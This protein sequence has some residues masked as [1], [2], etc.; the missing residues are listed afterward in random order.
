MTIKHDEKKERRA[1]EELIMQS[2]PRL[3][4]VDF[5]ERLRE[6]QIFNS[7]FTLREFILSIGIGAIAIVLGLWI[8]SGITNAINLIDGIECITELEKNFYKAIEDKIKT[9]LERYQLLKYKDFYP[10]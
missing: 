1:K 4:I 5:F 6:I 7:D 10:Y 9:T 8:S 2:R 3:D